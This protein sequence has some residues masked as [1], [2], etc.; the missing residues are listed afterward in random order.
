M[1]ASL[2]LGSQSIFILTVSL[3]QMDLIGNLVL[4]QLYELRCSASVGP[5]NTHRN[6]LY[7][8]AGTL[9]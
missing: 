8:V 7:A 6:G 3:L 5:G 9:L 1:A 4:V 2:H